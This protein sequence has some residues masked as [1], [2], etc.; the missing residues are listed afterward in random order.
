VFIR[1]VRTTWEHTIS[2]LRTLFPNRQTTASASA[3]GQ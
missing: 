2:D 1:T 3:L